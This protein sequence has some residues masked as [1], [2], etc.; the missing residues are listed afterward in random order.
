MCFD[1]VTRKTLKA[2]E[3]AR[4]LL[5]FYAL[6]ECRITHKSHKS[7]ALLSSRS[8]LN[9]SPSSPRSLHNCAS[10]P[11]LCSVKGKVDKTT[12]RSEERIVERIL[13][14]ESSFIIRVSSQTNSFDSYIVA[15][16]ASHYSS[17]DTF[18][19][20]LSITIFS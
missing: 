20:A 19:R 11:V 18:S 17:C 12:G 15:L 4:C 1:T 14:D 5:L 13:H 9:C 10:C 6:Q 7:P 3:L 16:F 2:L 8:V